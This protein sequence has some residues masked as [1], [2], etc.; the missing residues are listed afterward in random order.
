MKLADWPAEVL[1]WQANV[2][3]CKFKLWIH[4]LMTFIFCALK[5]V[6]KCSVIVV[7]YNE[8]TKEGSHISPLLRNTLYFF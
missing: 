8:R 2:W 1:T 6:L 4:F 3:I 5:R 7:L